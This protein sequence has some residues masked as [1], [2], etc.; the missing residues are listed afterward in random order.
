MLEIEFNT[1]IHYYKYYYLK[2]DLSIFYLQND[3]ST[4]SKKQKK[5][6]VTLVDNVFGTLEDLTHLIC[7]LFIYLFLFFFFLKLQWGVFQLWMSWKH[8]KVLIHLI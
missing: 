8:L 3:Y 1:I 7:S 4:L 2:N 6:I 5:K